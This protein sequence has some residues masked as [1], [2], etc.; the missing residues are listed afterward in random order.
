MFFV[1]LVPFSFSANRNLPAIVSADWLE[2]NLTDP[3]LVIVDIRSHE[4]FEKGHIPG[5][6]H[7]PFSRW[8]HH[9]GNVMLELPAGENIRNLI[10]ELGITGESQVVVVNRTDTDYNR[11]DATR[12]VWTCIVSGIVNASVLDGG[13]NRWLKLGKPVTVD[14]ALP[15]AVGYSGTTNTS[16]LISKSEVMNKIR[17]AILLDARIPEDYFGITEGKGHIKNAVNLPAPWAFNS[18]GTFRNQS[19]LKAMASEIVGRNAQKE[20]IVYCEVGGFASTWWFILS[21]VLGYA[22]VKLYDGSFQEWSSDPEAP[23]TRYRWD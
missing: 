17:S 4:L 6:V 19:D 21:E 20:I 11:A 2:R 15:D 8:I 3:N 23:V 5:A 18:D 13:Y 9:D 16:S 7:G 12:V 1:F 14:A 10:G 22:D